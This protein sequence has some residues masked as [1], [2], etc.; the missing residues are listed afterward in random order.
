MDVYTDP[1]K[2]TDS[3][4]IQIQGL[5]EFYEVIYFKIIFTPE[6]HKRK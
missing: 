5:L 4:F 1:I 6:Q 3:L 2:N